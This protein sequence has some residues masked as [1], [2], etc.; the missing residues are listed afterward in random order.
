MLQEQ[1]SEKNKWW[2]AC[3]PFGTNCLREAAMWRIH[4]LLGNDSVNTPQQYTGCFLCA[5]PRDRCCP[6]KQSGCINPSFLRLGSSWMWVVSFTPQSLYPREIAPDTH[7]IEGWVGPRTGLE[8][9]YKRKLLPLMGLKS[10]PSVAQRITSRHIDWA[11]PTWYFKN[12]QHCFSVW[13]VPIK[14]LSPLPHIAD[15]IASNYVYQRDHSACC[16]H[17]QFTYLLLFHAVIRE[18]FNYTNQLMFILKLGS[19]F[20]FPYSWLCRH[21]F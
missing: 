18:L 20:C 8:D 2:Y 15:D 19:F 9:L 3:R 4:S 7:W 13:A 14:E 6:I 16:R 10:D 5:P 17:F 12:F 11:I 21:K 1:P